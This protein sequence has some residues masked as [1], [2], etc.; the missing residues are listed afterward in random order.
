MINTSHVAAFSIALCF[1]LSASADQAAYISK[2]DADR[3]IQL[4]HNAGTVKSYCAPC[5]DARAESIAVNAIRKADVNYAGN[6]EVQ[7]NDQ[8]VDL[9]YLYFLENNKWRNVAMA[10]GIPVQD[11]PEFID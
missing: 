5:G 1:A 9:A 7:I 11:V 6:W 3:A 2:V 10:L 8:G 4:L